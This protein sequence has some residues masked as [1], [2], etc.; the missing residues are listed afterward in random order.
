MVLVASWQGRNWLVPIGQEWLG[1]FSLTAF[2]D[3]RKRQKQVEKKMDVDVDDVRDP[4]HE[5]NSEDRAI[6]RQEEHENLS[7]VSIQV[8]WTF[9]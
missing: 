5:Q 2:G 9:H 4:D 1:T 7:F 8:F 6:E 3:G